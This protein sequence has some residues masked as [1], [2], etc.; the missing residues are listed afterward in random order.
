MSPI[1]ETFNKTEYSVDTFEGEH[2]INE[3]TV[4]YTKMCFKKPLFNPI[5]PTYTSRV[6]KEFT[7][8]EKDENK[9]SVGFRNK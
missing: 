4:K 6:Y 3:Y 2:W 7:Q 5:W 1:L 9:P 8:E